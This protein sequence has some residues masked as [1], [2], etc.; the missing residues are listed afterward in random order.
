M[1]GGDDLR[2]GRLT[3]TEGR[4]AGAQGQLVATAESRG[5]PAPAPTCSLPLSSCPSPFLLFRQ[6]SRLLY[7]LRASFLTPPGAAETTVCLG[8]CDLGQRAPQ[9]PAQGT[10]TQ[11]RS[12]VH[13]APLQLPGGT[14]GPAM[15]PRL[16]DTT[17]EGGGGLGEPTPQTSTPS[18]AHQKSTGWGRLSTRS[19]NP[20][21][22][23]R[24][25]IS[26]K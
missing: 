8:V 14:A 24:G 25:H 10:T 15:R 23:T 4:G 1:Q 17:S 19:R 5:W 12:S 21:E 11:D 6:R 2:A 13:L 20:A 9:A 16:R 26:E 18:L 22:N 7:S 3:T